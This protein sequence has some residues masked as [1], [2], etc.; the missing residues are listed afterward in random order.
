MKKKAK[1]V[2]L[3][4]YRIIQMLIVLCLFLLILINK[5]YI[6][7]HKNQRHVCVLKA[8]T[9]DTLRILYFVGRKTVRNFS[10]SVPA[11]LYCI[12]DWINVFVFS[13]KLRVYK[14]F[15]TLSKKENLINN[16]TVHQSKTLYLK[17]LDTKGITNCT[18]LEVWLVNS[19]QP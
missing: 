11:V 8:P 10:L 3:F 6:Y 18:A 12:V 13:M 7:L 1:L 9:K 5:M 4:L 15:R 14:I 16:L 2:F 17:T 19:F